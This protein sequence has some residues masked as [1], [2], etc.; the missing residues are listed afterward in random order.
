MSEKT[1]TLLARAGVA[2]TGLMVGAA[3]HADEGTDAITALQTT[4]TSYIT[5]AFALTVLVVTGF[6]GIRMF[7][8][9]ARV[10]S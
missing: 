10:A 8:K 5:A 1:K 3:A 6:F 2:A 7:K 9:A 4:A